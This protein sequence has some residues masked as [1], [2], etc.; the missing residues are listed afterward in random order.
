[1]DDRSAVRSLFTARHD[2]GESR[3]LSATYRFNRGLTQQ[4]ELGWQWP[5]SWPS[6]AFLSRAAQPLAQN[7]SER[8]ASTTGCQRRWYS[9]GRMNY[10]TRDQRVTDALVGFEVDA[11]CW[12]SRLFV[13]HQAT[14]QGQSTTRLMFQLE[15]TGL[16]RSTSGPLRV[17]KDN[18]T[19]FRPL[20][21]DSVA[22]PT[23]TSP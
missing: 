14:G 13:E 23:G 19:G 21:E 16:S 15:L 8:A 5:L 22:T 3:L 10:S 2:A 7:P 4:W 17:L 20:R 6:L 12:T 9:L 18:A 11:G 1:M